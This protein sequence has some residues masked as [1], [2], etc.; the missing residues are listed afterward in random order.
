MPSV[1]PPET[2]GFGE[3]TR[4]LKRVRTGDQAAEEELLSRIYNELKQCARLLM[5][6]ERS[7]HTLQATALIHES[8]LRMM[9]PGSDVDWQDRNHFFALAAKEMRR[10]LCDHARACKAQKRPTHRHRLSLDNA[11][12]YTDD[13]AFEL[14]ELD[15]ALDRL[16]TWDPRQSRVVEMRF[17][18]DLTLE[19]I[20]AVLGVSSRTVRRD[21]EMA[22]AWLLIQLGGREDDAGALATP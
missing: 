14:L 2:S 22:R 20:A 7:D 17:F 19:E 1:D 5:R 9:R 18:G 16:G 13:L 10:V 4:L 3:I 15:D 12:V 8:F 6:N 21:W 11:I